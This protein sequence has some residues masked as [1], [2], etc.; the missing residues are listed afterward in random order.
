MTRVH[1]D[2]IGGYFTETIA[3][4]NPPCIGDNPLDGLAAMHVAGPTPLRHCGTGKG[5]RVAMGM[6][7]LENIRLFFKGSPLRDRVV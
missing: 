3:E 4:L 2:M 6:R 1:C 5:E 7:A